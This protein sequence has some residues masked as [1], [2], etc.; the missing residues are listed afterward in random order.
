MARTGAELRGE[1]RAMLGEIALFSALDDAQLNAVLEHMRKVRLD[2]G[3][4]L[5]DHGQP[6][7]QFFYARAGQ[8]KLFRLSADGAEKVIEIVR[9]GEMFA[10]AV[11]FMGADEGYP[12]SA[13][14]IVPSEL[15]AFD[16]AVMRGLLRDSVDTCFRIMARLS[17]RL[18]QHV[19]EIDRLTLHNATFR[20]VSFLLEQI[21]PHVLESPQ[22]RLVTPKHVIASRLAIKPETFS[23]LLSRLTKEGLIT[24]DRQSILVND[25]DGLRT[26]LEL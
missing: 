9:P 14:A 12:V 23:R 11:M 10:E 4:R 24:V 6:A 20:L 8:V 22:V 18:R 21:P 15:I 1:E 7:K 5:F 17:R 26:L 19:S 16:C 2:V 3:E 25:I 13:E